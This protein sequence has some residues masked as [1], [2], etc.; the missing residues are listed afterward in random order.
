MGTTM[1]FIMRVS[2]LQRS[3]KLAAVLYSGDVKQLVDGS[4]GQLRAKLCVGL[5]GIQD[6]FFI[7]G[8]CDL[9]GDVTVT[10]TGS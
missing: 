1:C 6:L 8:A 4:M 5:D 9:N 2:D 3:Q 7:L 10:E